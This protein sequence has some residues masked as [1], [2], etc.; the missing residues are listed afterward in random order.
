M[1]PS[2]RTARAGFTLIEL[3]IVVAILAI[4]GVVLFPKVTNAEQEARI[5]VSLSNM[6]DINRTMQTFNTITKGKYPDG[7]DS[8]LTAGTTTQIYPGNGN[9]TQNTGV[10]AAWLTSSPITEP[11]L[12]SLR[13]VSSNV[14][15]PGIAGSIITVF[16]HDTAATSAIQSTNGTA[17]VRTLATS[18]DCAFVDDATT[19]GQAVY[20]AFNL[21][22]DTSYRL[23]AVGFGPHVNLI[24]HPRVSIVE[25]PVADDITPNDQVSYRRFVGLFKV[26]STVGNSSFADYVGTVTSYGKSPGVL[27]NFLQS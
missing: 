7:W 4:L 1:R 12:N 25:A 5:T 11:E 23:F 20:T 10:F 13:R 14:I 22:P 17:N 3:L 26:D 16:D 6:A 8:L 18:S 19:Q 24:G 27:R 2:L 15:G 21:V 9:P